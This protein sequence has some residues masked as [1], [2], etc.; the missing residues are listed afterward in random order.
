LYCFISLN[1]VLEEQVMS[2]SIR[3]NGR[4]IGG[5][6]SI[7]I[8][9]GK[10]IV[11]GL[12]VTPENEKQITIEVTGDIASIEADVCEKI[13]VTG[14]AGGVKTSQGDINVGGN[15]NG[16]VKTS[17]GNIDIEGSVTG[18]VKTSQGNIK[19]KGTV[20]GK[21]STSMGNVTHG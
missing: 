2:S 20:S 21:A 8:V 11:D 16:D 14:N 18:D 4:N 10:V 15:V 13:T 9:N 7:V 1:P 12:D 17:Q 6:N 19:V 3:I 5:R